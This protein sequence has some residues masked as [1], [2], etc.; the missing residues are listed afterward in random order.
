[1]G[2]AEND[3]RGQI[4]AGTEVLGIAGEAVRPAADERA[5]QTEGGGDAQLAKPPRDE[6]RPES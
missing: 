3:E 6:E 4:D 5:L 1:M 2:A